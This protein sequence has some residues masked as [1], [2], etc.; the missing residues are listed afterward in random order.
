MLPPASATDCPIGARRATGTGGILCA[1]VAFTKPMLATSGRP[2]GPLD[3]WVV[4]PKADGWRAQLAVGDDGCTVWT[5]TGRD[6]SAKV[7]EVAAIVELGVECV[8]DGELVAG[9]GL[10]V[11][12]YPMAGLLAARRRHP[13][14]TFVAFDVLR[15]NGRSLLDYDLASR[16]EVLDCLVRLSDGSLTA[17]HVFR[18]CELDEVLAGC[19]QLDME[20]V[21]VKRRTSLYRPGRRTAEWRKVKCPAWRADHAERRIKK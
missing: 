14:L 21:V 2:S 5:R 11:D 8:F 7:P 15:L 17:V 3:G 12:F 13:R 18:G 6:T 9:A 1:V 10:P 4:E 19:E 16:R 20:G